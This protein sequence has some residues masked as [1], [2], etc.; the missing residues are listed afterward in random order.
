MPKGLLGASF[1]IFRIASLQLVCWASRGPVASIP[2]PPALETAA[3]SSG[4]E[5]HD[6]PGSMSGYLQP[7]ML[8][9]LVRIA[10]AAMLTV[11][12]VCLLLCLFFAMVDGGMFCR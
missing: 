2:I 6:M 7:S 11:V 4:V 12:F 10:G 1:R 8:V 3:T 5:I 9:I